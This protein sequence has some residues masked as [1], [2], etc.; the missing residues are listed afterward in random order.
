MSKPMPSRILLIEDDPAISSVVKYYLNKEGY[1][2][3]SISD[4]TKAMEAVFEHSPDLVI[5]DWMLGEHSGM[6]ILSEIRRDKEFANLPIIMISS[7][8]EE[9]D[10]VSGLHNG[11]DDYIVKPFLP[12]ELNARIQAIFR[13]IRPAFTGQTF[14]FD[15]IE[16]DL[17]AYEVRRN[18][19]LLKLAPI[20]F[21]IL[22][23]LIEQP[24]KV[25]SREHIMK[26]IWGP[27]IEV[28]FRT[29]DVHITRLRSALMSQS[30]RAGVDV[31]KTVRTM[32]YVLRLDPKD[33]GIGKE[34]ESLMQ[35]KK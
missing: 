3:T 6:D 28:G 12:I 13:R 29:I 32:G 22:Q 33:L 5:L 7:R 10:K 19:V 25:F 8:N 9:L 24:G 26:K 31:I 34:G 23:I 27:G 35:D 1:I 17:T 2:T 20:E 11:A 16:L 21:Q 15:D 4:A 14:T 18:G 30:Q